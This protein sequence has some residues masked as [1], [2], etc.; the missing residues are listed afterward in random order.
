MYRP[1][2]DGDVDIAG[3]LGL[4]RSSGYGGWFVLE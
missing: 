3:V 4:L 2:G 1:L